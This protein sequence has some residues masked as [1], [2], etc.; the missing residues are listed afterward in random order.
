MSKIDRLHFLTSFINLKI[1]SEIDKINGIDNGNSILCISSKAIP[2]TL[3]GNR[4]FVKIY[5]CL[6]SFLFPVWSLYF[7]LLAII[8]ILKIKKEPYKGEKLF[9]LSSI[10]LPRVVSNAAIKFNSEDGWLEIPWIK[11]KDTDD[12]NVLSVFRFI[13]FQDILS[14]Y[15]DSVIVVSY[16]VKKNG[17]QFV[18]PAIKCYRWFLYNIAVR[19]IPYHVELIFANHKDA[20]ATLIDALPHQNKTLVQHGTEILMDNSNNI[21]TTYYYHHEDGNY[22]SQNLPCRYNSLTK[23]Y[24]F[25]KKEFE[26]MKTAVLNC[27]PEVIYVG[28]SLKKF[29][30]NLGGDKAILI[31][32]YFDL[33]YEKERKL[34]SLLQNRAVKIYLKNHPLFPASVYSDLKKEYDFILLDGPI[35]P[36]VDYV[37]SY[38][39]TLA[40]E[41]EN[42]GAK[43]ILYNNMDDETLRRTV[44]SVC[45]DGLGA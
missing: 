35:F 45:R 14:A 17:Y 30:E 25:S 4:A 11:Y 21:G 5:L 20:F 13:G 37:F 8:N 9:L 26:A 28:Y 39:S 10:A 38:S 29:N 31:I 6:L 33:F 34:I 15:W 19:K 40:L 2:R 7:V 32:A 23:L 42:L 44:D 24:C 27:T 22:W 1:L 43:V 3:K 36:K 16:I 12:K 18:I 41:Y